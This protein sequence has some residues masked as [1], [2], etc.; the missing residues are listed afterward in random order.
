MVNSLK[1]EYDTKITAFE[2]QVS[3]LIKKIIA[4][5]PKKTQIPQLSE[6]FHGHKYREINTE[7]KYIGILHRKQLIFDIRFDIFECDIS[8]Y[9][10]SYIKIC[11]SEYR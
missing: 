11:F 2:A 6:F 7:N 10:I 8:D 4:L 1:N 9:D 3:A 5:E